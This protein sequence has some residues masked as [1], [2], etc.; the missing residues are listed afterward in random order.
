MKIA[1]FDLGTN[2]FN[3]LIARVSKGK[4]E[5]REVVKEGNHIGKGGF[6]PALL[7]QEA[8]D[9][10]LSV[11]D[12]MYARIEAAGGAQHIKAFATSAIRD[13]A[14]GEEFVK[15]LRERYGMDAQIIS[16]DRE[17]ELIYKGIRESVLL[18]NEKVLMLDIG[19]GS[20]ELIIADKEKIF[21]KESYPLGVIRMKEILEPSDPVKEDEVLSY[22]RFL[23]SKLETFFEQINIYKP[24]LL[25]GSS[26]S[27]DTLRELICPDDDGSLPAMELPLEKFAQL[28]DRLL[29]S[30]REERVKMAGMSPLRVDYIV[31]GSIFVQY[32]IRKTGITEMYQSSYSLKEGYMAEVA[33]TLTE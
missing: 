6:K 29:K 23:E 27:F 13:A 22:E 1:V 12:K 5:I 11:L 14:N 18:Y 16:G 8:I 10:S 24:K 20:N 31:L 33:A 32:I 26:G 3:L 25:I 21:W 19:G 15:L 28:H 17:A 9:S 30:T 2:V 7:T 4:C